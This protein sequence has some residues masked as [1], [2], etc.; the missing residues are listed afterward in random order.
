[1]QAPV[2]Y[3]PSLPSYLTYG[4]FASVAGHELSHAFDNNG[5]EYDET[6]KYNHWWD[7]STKAAFDSKTQCFTAQYSNYTIT[8]P[9][10]KRYNVNGKLTLG[11]NVAD[12]GG[13]HAGF[14]AWK[15]Q[16]GKN[17]AKL[18]GLEHFTHEQLFFINY[19]N[20]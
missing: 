20:W 12:A 18:P 4:A 15:S 13:V 1:M 19:A 7:N 3:D 14:V 9:G 16:I 5:A 11:E 2:F 8:G 17:D 10:G 6:G